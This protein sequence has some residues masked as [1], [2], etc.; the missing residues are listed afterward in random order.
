MGGVCAANRWNA[1]NPPLVGGDHVHYTRLG[2]E[3]IGAML[4]DDIE[5]A[6]AALAR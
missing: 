6:A 3:R 4:F 5:A 2:G 1:A